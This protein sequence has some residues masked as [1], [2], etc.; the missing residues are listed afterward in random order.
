MLDDTMAASLF[1]RPLPSPFARSPFQVFPTL[2]RGSC[3]SKAYRHAL[4]GLL[5]HLQLSNHLTVQKTLIP[6]AGSGPI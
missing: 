5:Q 2:L 4:L 3:L 1:R 6:N